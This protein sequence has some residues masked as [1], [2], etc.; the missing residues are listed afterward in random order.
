MFDSKL[1]E[2]ETKT[3]PAKYCGRDG[4]LGF[5]GMDPLPLTR[6]FYK[7]KAKMVQFCRLCLFI[8]DLTCSI[9]FIEIMLFW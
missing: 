7:I 8:L 2:K 3:S 5:G 9:F 1:T 4:A 6:K